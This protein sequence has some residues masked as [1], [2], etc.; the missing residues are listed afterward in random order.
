MLDLLTGLTIGLHLVSAHV[1]AQDWHNNVNPGV[2]VT[3]PDGYTA[4][5]YRNT[6][7]RTT[8][9]AGRAFTY[10]AFSLALGVASGYQ[11]IE[12]TGACKAGG[13]GTPRKPCYEGFSRGALSPMIVPSAKLGPVRLSFVPGFANVGS[14]VFHLSVE[15][16][17]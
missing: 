9:Y 10:G 3:T 6:L 2:Y 12:Y 13:I 7:D 15:H 8:F 17:F 16:T 11:R 1:P 4:G 14:S 5:V